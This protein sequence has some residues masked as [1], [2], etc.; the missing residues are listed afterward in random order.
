MNQC[1]NILGKPAVSRDLHIS[2]YTYSLSFLKWQIDKLMGCTQNLL[3]W[4]GQFL[5]KL[6]KNLIGIPIVSSYRENKDDVFYL[7]KL[8]TFR[9]N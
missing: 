4:F 8:F 1:I 5:L 9:P 2:F 3:L 6:F 7:N